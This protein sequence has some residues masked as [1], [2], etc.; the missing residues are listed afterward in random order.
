MERDQSRLHRSGGNNAYFAGPIDN[1]LGQTQY[2]A[3]A[4]AINLLALD[5][6]QTAADYQ[7]PFFDQTSRRDDLLLRFK[8]LGLQ[9]GR[10]QKAK[11]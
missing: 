3:W 11:E 5:A 9:Q 10:S 6:N 7:I 4:E 1:P 2:R 8:K